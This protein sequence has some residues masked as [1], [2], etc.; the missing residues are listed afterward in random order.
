MNSDSCGISLGVVDQFS[1]STLEY[2]SQVS[3]AHPIH[4]PS[5]R[6]L[7]VLLDAAKQHEGEMSNINFSQSVDDFV[8]YSNGVEASIS[9][10]HD[11]KGRPTSYK[12]RCKYLVGCDGAGSTIR[13]A[14]EIPLEGKFGLQ[15]LIN[16]H[17]FSS[18]L[19]EAMRHTQPAMLYFVFNS[20]VIAVLVAHDFNVSVQFRSVH[21]CTCMCVREE[22]GGGGLTSTQNLFFDSRASLCS[23]FH[24]GHHSSNPSSS[25][26]T[27][28][29]S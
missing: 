7:P 17:F 22:G 12:V 9:A 4:L 24:T 21:E 8:E 13:K 3:P 19:A 2:L 6:L 28:A 10:K 16:V 14:L 25:P 27:C 29:A 18:S 20:K 26:Q 1:G 15:H 23:S 11:F 5:N